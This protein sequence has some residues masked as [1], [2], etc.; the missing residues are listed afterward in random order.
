LLPVQIQLL[1]SSE[2]NDVAGSLNVAPS[3]GVLLLA[4]IVTMTSFRLR[5][6]AWS[7][8]HPGICLAFAVSTLVA[9]TNIGSLNR[10]IYL[11]KDFGLLVLC[12]GYAMITSAAQ[13]WDDIRRLLEVFVWSVVLQNVVGLAAFVYASSTGID[14]PWTLYGGQRLSGLLIDANGY[15]GLL[16]LTLTIVEVASASRKPLMGRTALMFSRLTLSLGLLF[17]FS[18]TAWI[19][20]L[21]LFAFLFLRRSRVFVQLAFCSVTGLVLVGALM[22][23]RLITLIDT[24]ARRGENVRSRFDLAESALDQFLNNPVTGGGIGSFLEAQGAIVHNTVLWILADMGVVGLVMLLGLIGWFV[25]AGLKALR[26]APREE[27]RLVTALCLGHITMFCLAMGIEAFYQRHWWFVMA[28]I[29]SAHAIVRREPV[30]EFR[31]EASRE[32]LVSTL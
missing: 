22:G 1:R 7:F 5:L 25:A 4:A 11:N 24:M 28:L 2:G 8:W 13:T 3:D 23:D 6:R 26:W 9:A 14:L 32:P 30:H 12:L 10:Y 16:S 19:S 29:G 15:G 31:H 27:R 17:T 21:P 18:R 20:L